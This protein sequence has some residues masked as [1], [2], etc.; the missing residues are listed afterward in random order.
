MTPPNSGEDAEKL[1]DSH[2]IDGDVKWS[3]HVGKHFDS[4]FKK[5]IKQLPCDLAITLLGIYPRQLKMYV[6]KNLSMNICSN[7]LLL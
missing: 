2:V 6:H 7:F 4:F 1:D 3:S 5:I